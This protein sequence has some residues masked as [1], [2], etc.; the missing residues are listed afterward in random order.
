LL[1]LKWVA[2]DVRKAAD[3]VKSLEKVLPA[4][5]ERW[6]STLKAHAEYGTDEWWRQMRTLPSSQRIYP[7]VYST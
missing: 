3:G 2:T 6:R 1:R 4:K 7:K 5:R